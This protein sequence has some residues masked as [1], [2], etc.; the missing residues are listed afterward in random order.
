[1]QNTQSTHENHEGR[2]T[3]IYAAAHVTRIQIFYDL[4]DWS[5]N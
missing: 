3:K 4:S 5:F 1:M 2:N